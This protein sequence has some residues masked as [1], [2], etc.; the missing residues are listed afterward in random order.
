MTLRDNTLCLNKS[1]IYVAGTTVQYSQSISEPQPPTFY[2]AASQSHGGLSQWDN[3]SSGEKR[4]ADSPLGADSKRLAR[5]NSDD[6]SL[7]A[8][9]RQ[10][11]ADSEYPPWPKHTTKPPS[12]DT[13]RFLAVSSI[14]VTT[15]YLFHPSTF[16]P[17]RQDPSLH[18]QT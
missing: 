13:H 3:F 17:C 16:I 1:T 2:H 7:T 14:T 15:A 5:G 6:P 11:R 18:L 10:A 9:P 12:I 8:L 4:P